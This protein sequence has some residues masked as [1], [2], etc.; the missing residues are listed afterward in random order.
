M[1]SEFNDS[2]RISSYFTHKI[3][4]IIDDFLLVFLI[5][6]WEHCQE[7]YRVHELKSYVLDVLAS[8]K[9]SRHISIQEAQTLF[10]R[11]L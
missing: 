10:Y 6:H 8:L 4:E 11:L 2:Q 5:A 9:D 1:E 7:D 3:E